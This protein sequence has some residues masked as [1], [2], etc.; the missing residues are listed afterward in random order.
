MTR[1][2]KVAPRTEPSKQPSQTL[3]TEKATANITVTGSGKPKETWSESKK[4]QKEEKKAGGS[5]NPG[6]GKF[7]IPSSSNGG[8]KGGGGG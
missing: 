1:A 7:A 8:N 3:S 5:A 4:R 2:V 6:D